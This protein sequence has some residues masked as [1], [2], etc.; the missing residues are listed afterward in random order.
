MRFVID[1]PNYGSYGDPALL[2]DLG[3]ESEEAGWDGFFVWDHLHGGGRSPVTDPWMVLAAVAVRTSRIRFGPMVTPL[4]RRRPQKVA[5]ESVTLDHLSGGRFVLGV[6]L[7]SR[8]DLEFA[9]FGDEK[10][11]KIRGALLDEGLSVLAGLWSG[12]P[13][14]FTGHHY[15]VNETTFRPIPVQEPRI[16]VWVAGKWPNR[17]P[18]R[19][20]SAWDGAFP[21]ERD[22]DLSVM[23][24]PEDMAEAITYVREHRTSS[25]PFD[26][27]HAGLLTGDPV[28]DRRAVRQYADVG[29][30]WWL[31]HVTPTRMDP[32]ELVALIR[33][34][35]PRVG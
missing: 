15:R 26:F 14:T 19:R 10:D 31:E 22:G 11:P 35:P 6:G 21:I 3:C 30:T 18:M 2:V 17:R 29:V 5:R 32:T 1:V 34:G 24:S 33:L 20:A 25:S 12:E 27:V 13:F 8:N 28:T 7:G 16:P 23:M 9:D 4:A